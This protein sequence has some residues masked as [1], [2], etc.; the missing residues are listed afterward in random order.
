[1]KDTTIIDMGGHAMLLAL[2]LGAPIL[3][4]ALVIGLLVG[5]LQSA[6]QLQEPTIS[7]VPK[8]LGVGV[9]L[10]LSGSWMLASAISYTHELFDSIPRLL[11]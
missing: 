8:L 7:F 10:M 3:A 4:T 11:R 1:M 2:K 6:T 9:T 5:M